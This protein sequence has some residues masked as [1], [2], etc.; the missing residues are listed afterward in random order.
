M[1]RQDDNPEQTAQR[2]LERMRSVTRSTPYEGRLYLVGGLLRDRALGLP[3][4]NDLDLVLEGDALELA[5]FFY[6]HGLSTHYPVLYPRFGTAMIHIGRADE[7]GSA[8]ELVSARAESYQPDSR[9]PDVRQGTIQDDVL[10]RDFTI[11][12]LLEN[13]HTG[14]QLDLT[15]HAMEDLRAGI[16]RTPLAPR[17]TFFDD[18]LR[19]L[20]AVRFAARFGFT[21]E[22]QTWEAICTEAARL[23]PPT[24]AFERIRE[25]FVKIARLPG[26]KFRRGMELLLESN[27]LAEF[28]PEML[29]MIGCT[30]GDWHRHDVWTHTLTA[31]ESLPDNARLEIRLALLWH[32]IGKPPTR[33]AARNPADHAAST[34]GDGEA[35]GNV[36]FYGHPVIGAEMVRTIMNRLKFSNEEIRDVTTLVAKHMRLG[37]YKHEWSDVPIKRLIRDCGSY[38]DDLFVL[39]LCDRSAV[40]IPVDQ[41]ADLV[42]LRTRIDA[43]NA[44]SDI[45][46]LE[47]PLDGN[48]IME[49]LNVGPG[50]HLKT[51]KD[52]LLNE[53]IEGRLSENDP[54]TA[55]RLL[56]IWWQAQNHPA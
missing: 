49:T 21:I 55:K 48:S 31:L 9:K 17:I 34:A 29:P 41:A 27:L 33:T 36:R 56:Q 20:R 35:T 13:L 30:Q 42:E 6:E 45:A 39:T 32:D 53:I 26:P 14:E 16:L 54:D 11:N 8:V 19:M 46:H 52:F 15:G 50:S 1:A 47:S 7:P 23:R 18:P 44:L 40:D 43:L 3:L 12:T 38:L 51:A 22:S 24:I 25:E 10:R 37:E 28:L 4:A 5:R 2:S